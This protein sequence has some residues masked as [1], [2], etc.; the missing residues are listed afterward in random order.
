M[1]SIL[2]LLSLFFISP[3]NAFGQTPDGKPQ[4]GELQKIGKVSGFV[5]TAEGKAGIE[6]AIVALFRNADTLPFSGGITDNKG[7]FRVDELIPGNY[8]IRV[9]FLSF[10]TIWLDSIHIHPGKREVFFEQIEMHEA[11]ANLNEVKITAEKEMIEGGID[12]KVY[13]VGKDISSSGSTIADVLQNVPSV[14]LD[15]DRNVQL[16]GSGN[17]NILIDGKP[18]TLSGRGGLDQLPAS[19]VDKVEIIKNLNLRF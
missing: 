3:W 1:R 2:V 9:S 4:G 17:V 13:N 15:M 14:S 19:M 18:S 5:K 8:R 12:K 6:Y 16:R 10:E 7:F 11:I